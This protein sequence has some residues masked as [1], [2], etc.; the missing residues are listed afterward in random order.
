MTAATR[1]ELNADV[2][3]RLGPTE[4]SYYL[5]S[6]GEGIEGGVN[7]MYLHIGFRARTSIVTKERVLGAWSD[8]LYRHPLLSATAEFCDYS[9]IRFRMTPADSTATLHPRAVE[10]CSF[11]RGHEA[12][13]LIATYL[14]G[15]RTLSD[16]CLSRLT[17]SI[18][19]VDHDFS[20]ASEDGTIE[21]FDFVL[22]STHFL[23]DGMALHSTAHEFFSLLTAGAHS[24]IGAL[25]SSRQA[26]GVPAAMED[27]LDVKLATSRFADAAARVDFGREQARQIGGHAFPKA[28][29]GTRHT[30]VPTISYSPEQTKLALATCKAH[31][32]SIANAMF[33]L[34]TF[35]YLRSVKSERRDPKLPVLMYS[36]LN[37]RPYLGK[38]ADAPSDWYH[39]A[40]GYYNIVLPS[41]L[42]S[43]TPPSATFWLRAQSVK[44]QTSKVIKSPFL[45]SRTLLMAKKRESQSIGWER[46]ADAKKQQS[47]EASIVEGLNGLKTH[48]TAAGAAGK[49]SPSTASAAPSSKKQ[50]SGSMTLPAKAPQTALMGL[51]MLGNLDG[52]YKHA[53]YSGVELHSLTTGSRQ[54]PGAL[55][56]FAYTFAGKLWISLGYD[57]NG[58]ERGVI[59]AWWKELLSGVGEFLLAGEFAK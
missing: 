38:T 52:M 10:L 1:Y 29:L 59:E 49:A 9:D 22:F 15:P 26:R 25:T 56:L 37:I 33:A 55:L 31:G 2:S 28:R 41:F 50:P 34:S 6:R 53:E 20:D 14:N 21:E 30:L 4:A 5:G 23:G 35:A 51:S 7:D 8:I 12:K 18:P 42:P 45:T 36:A 43:T 19:V 39:I 11:E 13:A 16:Q 58:F 48:E 46:E 57:S 24:F 44:K 47:E 32:V 40:I 17:K 27:Q 54:R 3:R